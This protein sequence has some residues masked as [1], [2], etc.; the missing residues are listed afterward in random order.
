LARDITDIGSASSKAAIWRLHTILYAAWWTATI[1]ITMK[2]HGCM[3][4][5]WTVNCC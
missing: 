5:L 1:E 3:W 2:S 4:P